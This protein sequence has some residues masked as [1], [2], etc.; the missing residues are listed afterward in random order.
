MGYC[1]ADDEVLLRLL[2]PQNGVSAHFREVRKEYLSAE[3]SSE[4]RAQRGH[5]DGHFSKLG[6]VGV[7]RHGVGTI[8][9]QIPVV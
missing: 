9:E 6:P 7:G 4:L 2:P 3:T 5:G 1:K 8:P